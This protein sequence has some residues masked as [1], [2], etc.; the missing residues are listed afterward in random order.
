MRRG[1]SDP[2]PLYCGGGM[3][4]RHA[5]WVMAGL[6]WAQAAPAQ[7]LVGRV[8]DETRH[9]IEGVEVIVNRREV[10]ATT[11]SAGVFQIEVSRTDSTLAFRRIGYRPMLFA[12]R[13]L[14]S[15]DDTILVQL[16]G[17]PV[18]L[19]EVVVSAEPDKP[20]RYAGTTKYDEVFLRQKVGLGTLIS[21]D[22]IETRFGFATDE[23]LR[24]VAGIHIWNGPPK[25]I[26]F[27]RCSEPGGVAIF[28]DGI[29]QIPSSS[30]G[31]TSGQ[32]AT[33]LIMQRS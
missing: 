23:L 16:A 25:R 18:R 31:S 29:R 9:P 2:A 14:P 5:V 1:G 10:R 13:P 24:G 26:R 17:G 30:L 19:A 12:M 20:L 33:G 4:L 6:A 27:T 22:A 11:D 3:R 8:F 21:R 7:R 28:I 32:S 15:P